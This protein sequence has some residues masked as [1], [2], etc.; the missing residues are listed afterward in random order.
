MRY[1]PSETA[2]KHERILKEASQLFRE[3][4]F[5]DV[6]VSEIMQASGL[7]HGPF[8]NHFASKEA[9]MA[10]CIV[11]AMKASL[12]GVKAAGRSTESREKY[13]HRYLSTAHRD[14]A[15]E[16]CV[17]AALGGQIRQEPAV[18][19]PFTECLKSIIDNMS[20]W[21]PSR[22]K[23]ASRNRSIQALTSMVGALIL[24]RA[25]DDPVLSEEILREVREGLT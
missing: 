1:P 6:S 9:L 8:Y 7:T 12:K 14:T 17:M 15:G 18:R 11:H 22:S 10:E 20:S 3:R 23:Q 19:G 13:I 25:V 24:S 4:G 16:G 21:F 2:E 5:S